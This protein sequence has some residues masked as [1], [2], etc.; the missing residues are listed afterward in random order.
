MFLIEC[1]KE[2]CV[3]LGSNAQDPI[4]LQPGD[5]FPLRSEGFWECIDD[6]STP[7][8]NASPKAILQITG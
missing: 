5:V 8:S 2:R 1:F 7:C 6:A 3:L 4:A